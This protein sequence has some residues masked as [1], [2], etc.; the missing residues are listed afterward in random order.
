MTVTVK[1]LSPGC[2]LKACDGEPDATVIPFTFMVAKAL[3]AVDVTVM[4]V[5]EVATV[6]L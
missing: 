4:V 2:K 5:T 3:L 6:V 1:L